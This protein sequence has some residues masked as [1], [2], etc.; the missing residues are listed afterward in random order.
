MQG[1]QVQACERGSGDRKQRGRRE[2]VDSP[3]EPEHSGRDNTHKHI[4]LKDNMSP[5]VFLS[6]RAIRKGPSL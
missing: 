3:T 1:G 4:Y 2:E 5:A 6:D